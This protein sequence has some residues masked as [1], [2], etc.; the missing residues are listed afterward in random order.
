[1]DRVVALKV[2]HPSIL[3]RPGLS[4]RFHEEAKAV[5]RL[6]HPNIATAYDADQ[7]GALHFLV[8]EHVPGESLQRL[9]RRGPCPSTGPAASRARQPWPCSTPTSKA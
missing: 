2:I 5:A 3:S 8:M 1:M 7:A 9:V 4:D 6:S